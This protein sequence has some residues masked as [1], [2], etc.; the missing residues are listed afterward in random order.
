MQHLTRAIWALFSIAVHLGV[1]ALCYSH[2]VGP[3]IQ[4]QSAIFW[5]WL[6]A[7]PAALLLV[8]AKWLLWGIGALVALAVAVL[9]VVA[10]VSF[11]RAA[12]KGSRE[13]VH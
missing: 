8:F 1:G 2:F 3:T 11:I 6:L 7:W 9:I 12:I 10:A 5:G 13:T 4:P